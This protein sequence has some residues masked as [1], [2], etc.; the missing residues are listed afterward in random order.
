ML[1]VIYYDCLLWLKRFTLTHSVGCRFWK[2]I[3]EKFESS[4][5]LF[6]LWP[7]IWWKRGAYEDVLVSGQLVNHAL[8]QRSLIL[9]ATCWLLLLKNAIGMLVYFCPLLRISAL[10]LMVDKKCKVDDIEFTNGN[11]LQFWTIAFDID[12]T[13]CFLLVK[14]VQGHQAMS[15]VCKNLIFWLL[16]VITWKGTSH[17]VY[18]I[19]QLIKIF[20]YFILW[21]LLFFKWR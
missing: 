12:M 16:G 3:N 10:F 18:G 1:F 14:W 20:S 4:G 21:L 2:L 7:C 13:L 11:L 5:Y 8:K 15:L 17:I 6:I 9:C 19:L